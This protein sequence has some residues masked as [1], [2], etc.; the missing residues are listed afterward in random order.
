MISLIP[1]TVPGF[2]LVCF[3]RFSRVGSLFAGQI[4]PGWPDPRRDIRKAA[5]PNGPTQPNPTRGISNI[6]WSD[7]TRPVKLLKSFWPDP[8][9]R[10][11]TRQQP[12]LVCFFADVVS[13]TRYTGGYDFVRPEAQTKRRKKRRYWYFRAP[14]NLVEQHAYRR[15]ASVSHILFFWFLSR[16]FVCL[17]VWLLTPSA[18]IFA[19]FFL[20]LCRPW[21]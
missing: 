19:L 9:G 14:R 21:T 13:F 10:G 20:N 4:G 7:P 6:S 15:A 12:C 5:D 2:L 18:I 17:L 16:L 1:G 3:Q 8:R 11:M